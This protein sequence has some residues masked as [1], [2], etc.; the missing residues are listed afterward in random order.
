[1]PVVGGGAGVW[2]FIEIT[3]AAAATLAAV[4]RGELGV[5]NVVD[6]DPAPVAEWLPY[7][8]QVAGANRRCG[9]HWP[10]AAGRGV[11]GGSDA[12]SRGYSNGRP[13]RNSAG[14]RGTRLAGGIRAW[15][16]GEADDESRVPAAAS[17]ADEMTGSVGDAED[18]VQDA[19]L[20]LR[21]IRN[22]QSYG[23]TNQ[24]QRMVMARQLLK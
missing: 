23:G 7:L 20:G 11:R 1:M 16:A 18:I 12:T 19:F 8:A 10:A 14:S 24:I 3:D 9:C 5:Y 22:T 4:G 21:H 2:S 6:D 17:I 13:G 15:V